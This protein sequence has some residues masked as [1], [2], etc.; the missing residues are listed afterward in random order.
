[1]GNE[2]KETDS[3]LGKARLFSKGDSVLTR[4]FRKKPDWI[5]GELLHLVSPHSWLIKRYTGEVAWCHMDHIRRTASQAE[6]SS[7][8]PTKRGFSNGPFV[9]REVLESS[10]DA[11]SSNPH[12]AR[13]L[14]PPEG[15]RPS[16]L[17]REE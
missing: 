2:I 8:Q 6:H 12:T 7:Q 9:S 5:P 17:G 11:P 13:W 10:E 16:G 15:R 14:R 3:G 4:Q 1:M